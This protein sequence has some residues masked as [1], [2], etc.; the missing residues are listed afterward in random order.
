MDANTEVLKMNEYQQEQLEALKIV[1]LG[2][3]QLGDRKRMEL[4]ETIRDYMQFRQSVDLF[5]KRYFSDVCNHTCYLSRSSACCSKDGIITFFADTVINALHAAPPQLDRLEAVLKRV[6]GGHRCVY[7]GSH[8]CTWTIRPVVCAMFLCDRAMSAVFRVDPEG[9][10]VWE[11][12]RRQEKLFKWPD[13]PVLFDLLEKKFLD[14][15]YQS[16]LMHLN[17]GPGLLRVKKEAGLF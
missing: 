15:G 11:S 10:K 6:N 5:L 13:R 12:L 7:L 1:R 3:S 4:I 14:L 8:G 16:T 2:L 9:K 17:L